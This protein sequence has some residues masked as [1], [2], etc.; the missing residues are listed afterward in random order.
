MLLCPESECK[1]TPSEVQLR[2]ILDD[3]DLCSRYEALA[4]RRALEL[5]GILSSTHNGGNS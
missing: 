5:M 2:A 3:E 4:L 1:S